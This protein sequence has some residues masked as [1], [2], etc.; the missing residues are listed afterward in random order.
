[1]RLR[2]PWRFRPYGKRTGAS[3]GGI[4]EGQMRLRDILVQTPLG[5]ASPFIMV[6]F[7]DRPGTGVALNMDA[8]RNV[9]AA[10]L[11]GALRM[12]ADHIDKLEAE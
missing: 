4:V 12:L 1:M 6:S 8:T 9:T 3:C 11:A 7:Y 10:E 2:M 5:G